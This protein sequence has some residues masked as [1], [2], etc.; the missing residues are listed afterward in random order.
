M[1]A[2]LS[3]FLEVYDFYNYVLFFNLFTLVETNKPY[4]ILSVEPISEIIYNAYCRLY[5]VYYFSSVA[6]V[7]ATCAIGFQFV[8][9]FV[10]MF[11]CCRD[12]IVTSFGN[13]YYIKHAYTHL[14]QGKL[15]HFVALISLHL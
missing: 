12:D 5:T 4:D 15:C 10:D 3:S 14:Y 9:L 8:S 13:I 7:Y 6:G 11:Y 2:C 1:T